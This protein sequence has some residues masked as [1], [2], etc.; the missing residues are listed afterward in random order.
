MVLAHFVG[1][2]RLLAISQGAFW[3]VFQVLLFADTRIYNLFRYHFNG[4]VLNLVY[5]RGSEDSIHLGWQVW[6]AVTLGLLS[7]GIG[8]A[9]IW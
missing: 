3:T 6:T 8:Q 9:W 4:Q 7:V 2:M 5:T 1:R